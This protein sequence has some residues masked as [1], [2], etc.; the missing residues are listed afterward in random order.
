MSPEVMARA[1]DPFFTTKRQGEGTG[2]G[3]CMVYGFL[4]Q[5]KGHVKIY[6]ELGVGTTIK[7]YLPRAGRQALPAAPPAPAEMEQGGES[8]L[9]VEDDADVRRLVVQMLDS[10]GYRVRDTATATDAL[11]IIQGGAPIDL[12]LTDVVL[13]SGMNGR[14]LVEAARAAAPALKVLY[15]SGYTENAIMHQDR[16]EPGVHL[17]Q[18]PFRKSDVAAKVRQALRP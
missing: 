12:M 6:S 15:M 8:V 14:G 17:L 1:F 16:L 7:L 10:L 5:S 2:L 3:L 9:V 4:K 11:A 18:K 13:G